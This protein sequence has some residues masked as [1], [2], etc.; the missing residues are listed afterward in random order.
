[1]KYFLLSMLLL[2]TSC[3]SIPAFL[4]GISISEKFE[5]DVESKKLR[6]QDDMP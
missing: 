5:L 2:L 4:Q 6:A 3:S 1:M